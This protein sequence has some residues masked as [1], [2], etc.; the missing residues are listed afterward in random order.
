MMRSGSDGANGR[1]VGVVIPLRSLGDGK[2]R[3]RD[4]LDA[5]ERRELIESMA[6][7]VVRACHELPVLIVYDDPEV[8]AW[9]SARGL[10]AIEGHTPGLD[11]AVEQGVA[12]FAGAGYTHVIVAHA[13]LPGARDLRPISEFDGVT[14]VPDRLGDGTNVV[15]VPTDIG[16]TF[17]YG[18]GS[19]DNHRR[20][21]RNCGAPLRIVEDDD[22]AWDV[23]HPD[24]LAGA[25]RAPSVERA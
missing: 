19:F 14:L 7:T 16:F 6:Q 1:R 2:L 13:D 10:T 21:A 4:A 23:D 5:D 17:A 9:A 11:S 12:E 22:L 18:P 24:D 8:G 20:I 25:P 15:C 3:L